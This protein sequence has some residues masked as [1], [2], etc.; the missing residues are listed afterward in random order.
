MD[1]IADQ[2]TLDDLNLTGRYNPHSVY[3]LF[4]KVM[5][6]GGERLLDQLFRHPLTDPDAI[7]RRSDVFRHFA[8]LDLQFPFDK[9][10]VALMEGY[11]DG[12]SGNAL[13]ARVG[14]LRK[15]IAAAVTRDEAYALLQAGVGAV[16]DVLH[17]LTA[18]IS[19]F[20]ENGPYGEEIRLLKGILSDKLMAALP[21]SRIAALDHL[22][23]HVLRDDM[24]RLLQSIY[25]LD[26]N[27]AVG[28]VARRKGLTYARALPKERRTFSAS[29]LRHPG[30]DKAVANPL[31]LYEDKNMLFLTGA[32]MAGKSTLMKSFGI[33][34]YLSHIGFPVAAEN[35]IFSVRDGLYS[36]INVPDNLSLG[37][38]HFYAEVLR[39]KKVAEEVSAGRDLVVIFDELF[40]GTNVKDAYDAT[41]AVTE[42]FSTYRNCLF[43]ISTHITEVGE[44]LGQRLDNLRFAYLPTRMEGST[45]RYTYRLEEGISADRHGMLIIH[46][47]RI[48][49][50]IQ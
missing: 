23:R 27:I 39:V 20:P 50:L 38:S 33:A 34:V 37:Y 21:L 41:L 43:V 48:L 30:I 13:T 25:A 7:N 9:E 6:E 44:T 17:G 40:K 4:N 1:F 11:L 46:N 45:P 14:V 16:V 18:L 5:T 49:N 29:A 31:Y 12:D 36:S 10:Q 24:K 15:M 47:E 3:S 42:A 8:D 2:Q 35:M 28:H 26:V 19:A 32:N 22:F